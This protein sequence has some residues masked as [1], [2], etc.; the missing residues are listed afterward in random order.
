[1]LETFK[2]A[3]VLQMPVVQ[4]RA[5][6]VEEVQSF[7]SLQAANVLRANSVIHDLHLSELWQAINSL[8]EAIA[9]SRLDRPSGPQDIDAMIFRGVDPSDVIKKI[10]GE[11][12]LAEPISVPVLLEQSDQKRPLPVFHFVV[13]I[14]DVLDSQRFQLGDYS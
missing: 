7:V 11:P 1:M 10:F 2:S 4:F 9:A 14:Q 13:T 8:P 6:Q 5:F 3:D 12:V